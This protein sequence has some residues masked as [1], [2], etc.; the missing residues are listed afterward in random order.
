MRSFSPPLSFSSFSSHSPLSS[1]RFSSTLVYFVLS[2]IR[3]IFSSQL[4]VV[5]HITHRVDYNFS[6]LLNRLPLKNVVYTDHFAAVDTHTHTHTYTIRVI[7]METLSSC[8]LLWIPVISADGALLRC[9]IDLCDFD[10]WFCWRLHSYII[11]LQIV[12][13]KCICFLPHIH[14]VAKCVCSDGCVWSDH[15]ITLLLFECKQS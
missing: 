9:E 14:V 11:L 5:D 8:F 1:S 3:N 6:S 7:R 13:F 4:S 10:G 15:F 12:M 2:R